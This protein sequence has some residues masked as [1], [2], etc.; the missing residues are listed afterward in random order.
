[1]NKQPFTLMPIVIAL[2]ACAFGY[3]AHGTFSDVAGQM[4]GKAFPGNASGGG[5]F[6]LADRSGQLTCDGRMAPPDRSPVPGSCQGE[7]GAGVVRCSDGREVPVHWQALTCRSFQGT[8]E[9]KFGNRLIF[10][11]DRGQ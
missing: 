7:S 10:R 4:R 11:V 9:D 5:R 1:M 3:Q 8:G 6:M 2:A